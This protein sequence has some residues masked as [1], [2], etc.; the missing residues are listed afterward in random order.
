MMCLRVSTGAIL[1]WLIA[2]STKM[3]LHE[4]A[5]RCLRTSLQM[6]LHES[7]DVS[8]VGLF[9]RGGVCTKAPT[10]RIGLNP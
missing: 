4:A 10:S 1:P 2:V 8:G 3:S 6:A 5:G 9:E 7:A